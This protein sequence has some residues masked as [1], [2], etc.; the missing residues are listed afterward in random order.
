MNSI[1]LSA[2]KITISKIAAVILL[3]IFFD[4][5]LFLINNDRSIFYPIN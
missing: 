3:Y 5:L 1:V 2:I 4:Y